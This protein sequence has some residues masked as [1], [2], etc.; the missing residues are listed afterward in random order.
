MLLPTEVLLVRMGPPQAKQQAQ[1][2]VL[3]GH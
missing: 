1:R 3:S 2:L